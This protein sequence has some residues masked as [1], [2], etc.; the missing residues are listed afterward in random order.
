MKRKHNMELNNELLETFYWQATKSNR[1]IYNVNNILFVIKHPILSMQLIWFAVKVIGIAR[2]DDGR[3][4]KA[5]NLEDL[6]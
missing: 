3:L 4:H 6:S 1:S 2:I 5:L